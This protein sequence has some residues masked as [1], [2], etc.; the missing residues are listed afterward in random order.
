MFFLF[1][2]SLLSASAT[3]SH[4]YT[5]GAFQSGVFRSLKWDSG[6]STRHAVP[7]VPWTTW[8]KEP[9]WMDLHFIDKKKKIKLSLC[10]TCQA[11]KALCSDLE[12]KLSLPV[13]PTAA[14]L[15]GSI[16]THLH[17]C[18]ESRE[19]NW[20]LSMWPLTPTTSAEAGADQHLDIL[21]D[22]QMIKS[23]SDD[24][25]IKKRLKKKTF[26]SFHC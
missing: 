22:S 4:N 17:V 24:S 10:F 20:S 21:T 14:K 5:Q 9:K 19:F 11:K 23:A 6:L 7:I 2:C 3:F 15:R 1:F 13:C 12:Q 8:G 26:F 16:S 25:L 18:Q